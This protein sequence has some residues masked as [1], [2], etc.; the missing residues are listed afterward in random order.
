MIRLFFHKWKSLALGTVLPQAI[1]LAYAAAPAWT[2]VA[3]ILTFLQ[4]ILPV[5]TVYL[6]KE[7]VDGLAAVIRSGRSWE[8]AK[9]VL[10][11]AA[12]MVGITLV[13]EALRGVSAWIRSTQAELVQDHIMRLVHQKSIEV[14]LTFYDSSDFFDHL[15]RARAEA[16]YRPVAVIDALSSLIQ[17]TITLVA[18]FALLCSFGPVLPIALVVSTVPA[19]WVV[20]RN[21]VRQHELRSRTTLDERRTWYYDWLLTSRESAAEL[22]LFGIGPLFVAAYQNLR[23]GIRDQRDHL[24]RSNAAAE[25]GAGLIGISVTAGSMAWMLWRT[26]EGLIGVG[27]LALFH[28]AFQQGLRLMRSLLDNVGQL[29]QNSLFLTNL[30][31]F[32][33]LQPLITNEPHPAAIPGALRDGLRFENVTFRYPGTEKPAIRN[34]HLTIPAGQVVAFVGPNGAGKSSLIKLLC[35]FYEPETG[36][37]ELDG[38]DI[39]LFP[40]DELRSH[41]A[42]LF[43]EPVRYNATVA[44]NIG[45]KD[46]NLLSEERLAKAAEAADAIGI[47]AGL[48]HGYRN[49]LGKLF[50]EGAELSGGQWQRLALARA[51][52]RSAPILVLDEPTSAMDPWA[53]ADWLHGFR[54]LV[55]GR[56]AILITHRFTTAMKADMIYV[57]AEGEIVES[58]SHDELLQANGLYAQCWR[59]QTSLSVAAGI[60]V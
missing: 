21:A 48:P 5:A 7:L 41:I 47:I 37:I 38:T 30:F 43:Q 25:F 18:M 27:T 39:R 17:N 35:R 49:L 3:A 13:T 54:S 36:R 33:A 45:I 46:P 24:A 32:L 6:V 56:T 28:Q 55:C 31:E 42:A 2:L 20:L 53:E 57:M 10:I 23:A 1:R 19:F 22:R 26:L 16:W 40:I 12:L 52:F 58:G 8:Q 44:Q 11:A 59:K 9:P 34:F 14:D 29:Y 15:H 4:G 60:G 50:L 51:L